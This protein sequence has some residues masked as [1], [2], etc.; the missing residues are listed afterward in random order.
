MAKL[1]GDIGRELKEKIRSLSREAA[2]QVLL[3][4]VENMVR[5]VSLKAV[6][7]PEYINEAKKL[8]EAKNG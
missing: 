6:D 2:I 8:S 1:D 5:S 4:I 3:G 7:F